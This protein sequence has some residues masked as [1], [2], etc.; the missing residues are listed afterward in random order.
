MKENCN[1]IVAIFVGYLV[2]LFHTNSYSA[3]NSSS[4][5]TT[6][7]AIQLLNVKL[8]SLPTYTATKIIVFKIFQITGFQILI[9][10]LLKK[11][12]GGSSYNL[13]HFLLWRL[14]SI[15]FF[16]KKDFLLIS[17]NSQ[18]EKNESSFLLGSLVRSKY[19]QK[20]NNIGF[21]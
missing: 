2:C 6:K 15:F 17:I 12:K 10:P 16:C 20:V 14:S 9:P 19:V 21:F 13:Y 7:F 1:S 18:K 8:Y 5:Q 4:I 3:N 11:A